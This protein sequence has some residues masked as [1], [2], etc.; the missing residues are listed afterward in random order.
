MTKEN[1]ERPTI[2]KHAPGLANKFGRSSHERTMTEIDGIPVASL[3]EKYGS[4]LFVFSE[5]TIRKTYREALNTF[6]VRYPKVQFA[7]SYKTNY[8]DAICKIYHQEGSWAEVVSE[9]EYEMARRLG[10]PGDKIL[11]NGPYKPTEALKTAVEE[12]AHIHIDHFDE[13]YA[14]ENIAKEKGKPINVSM[15]LNMDTGIYPSWDRFGFNYDIGE[16]MSA[17][18][19]MHVGG[20]LKLTGVHA[21]SAPSCSNRMHTGRAPPNLQPLPNRSKKI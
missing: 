9:Y 21:T 6:K 1:Y 20:M 10:V 15:R 18:Q 5:K 13:L 2:V 16:A 4:P 17:A 11:F 7:W 19:R 8:L 12:G 3:I 14:L